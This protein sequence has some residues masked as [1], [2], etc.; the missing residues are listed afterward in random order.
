MGYRDTQGGKQLLRT[1]DRPGHG[2]LS[3]GSSSA[4]QVLPKELPGGGTEP[5][6]LTGTEEEQSGRPCGTRV[7]GG[8]VSR[9]GCQRKSSG[10][11]APF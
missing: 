4:G 10:A 7:D 8:A 5:R 1:W 6:C 3:H 9:D 11:R 2:A